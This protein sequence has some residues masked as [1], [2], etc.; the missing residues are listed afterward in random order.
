MIL[1]RAL[2][3]GLALLLIN[4]GWVWAFPEAS[5]FYI[6]NVVLHL[7]FLLSHRDYQSEGVPYSL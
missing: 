5:L 1:N 4:S 7:G 6:G 2:A 3:I